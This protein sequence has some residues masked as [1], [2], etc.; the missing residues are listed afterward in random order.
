MK[1]CEINYGPYNLFIILSFWVW[2]VTKDVK[3]NSSPESHWKENSL[4]WVR[5]ISVLGLANK[6]GHYKYSLIS[7]RS[8]LS[9]ASLLFF[10][11]L[12]S[13][14]LV[15]RIVQLNS[16]QL[17]TQLRSDRIQIQWLSL[18]QI[19]TPNQA[20]NLS[21]SFFPENPM[22]PETSSPRTTSRYTLPF[23]LTPVSLSPMFAS[24]T[25]P[26]LPNSLQGLLSSLSPLI[27]INYYSFDI[28]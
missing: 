6:Y 1:I 23:W 26:F 12:N 18:S 21:M 13:A 8:L 17:Q 28:C 7:P 15:S 25:T 3:N 4:G 10:H 19:S 27:F 11:L 14:S 22:F 16:T 9:L 24:G 5:G 20:S 2:K